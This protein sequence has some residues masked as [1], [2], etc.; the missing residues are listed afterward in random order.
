LNA[1]STRAADTSGIGADAS[2]ALPTP[3]EAV[4]RTPVEQF[5]LHGR[6][7]VRAPA[8]AAQLELVGMLPK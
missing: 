7:R 1:R 2:P 8:R 3:G 4:P 6:Q 5:A